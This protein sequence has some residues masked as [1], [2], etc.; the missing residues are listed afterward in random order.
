M[1]ITTQ[2]Q[3]IQRVAYKINPKRNTLKCIFTK[4]MKFKH[5][6]QIIKSIKGKETIT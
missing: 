4:L 5:K 2:V 6:E 3:E 1:E